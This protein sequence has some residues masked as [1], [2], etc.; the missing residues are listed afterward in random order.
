[1]SLTLAPALIHGIPSF[2]R[3][4]SAHVDLK[5]LPQDTNTPGGLLV[6]DSAT[7]TKPP[8]TRLMKSLATLA[9]ALRNQLAVTSTLKDVDTQMWLPSDI[10]AS[11]L[12]AVVLDL[13]MELLAALPSSLV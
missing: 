10:A 13:L 2:A 3:T 12:A 5:K 9:L 7:S 6:V 8:T 11:S 4:T 1:M